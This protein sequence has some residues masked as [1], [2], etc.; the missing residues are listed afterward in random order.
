MVRQVVSCG[1]L[2]LACAGTPVRSAPPQAAPA[3]ASPP[4]AIPLSRLTPDAVVAIPFE[5]GAVA[6]ADGI[7]VR[8]RVPGTVT[9]I[10]AKTNVPGTPITLGGESCAPLVVAFS[11]VWAPLCAGRG[12]VR[13]DPTAHTLTATV[14]LAAA[15][16]TAGMASAVGS[17]WVIT[18]RRG[19]IARLDPETNTPVAEVFVPAGAA[20]LAATPDALWV[21]SEAASRLTRVNPHTNQVTAEVKTGPKPHRLAVGEGAVWTLNGNGTV[22]RVDPG[23]NT[24]VETITVGGDTSAGDIAAGAGG[25]WVSVLGTPLTRIDPRTNTAAQRFTAEA[26]GAVL[27]AHRSLWVGRDARTTW[28]LDP[29]LVS[30]V[31]P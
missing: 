9:R 5:P 13:V 15:D 21:V 4:A 28:R 22:T 19:V 31:R 2:V 3:T 26:G 29:R 1:L 25:V 10:D 11:H 14:P 30:T 20:A 17:I 12:L 23:T 6:D 18:E 7:W 27:V 24:A 16:G 8:H